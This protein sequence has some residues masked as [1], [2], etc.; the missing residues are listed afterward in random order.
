[1][2]GSQPPPEALGSTRSVLDEL[3]TLVTL[4]SKAG[5]EHGGVSDAEAEEPRQPEG[6]EAR[7]SP[8]STSVLDDAGERAERKIAETPEC[9]SSSGVGPDALR[10]ADAI[11][12]SV[13]ESR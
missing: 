9:R 3:R 1:M 11:L 4:T 5:Q 6:V 7:A 13:G 10:L 12:A 8:T 2:E